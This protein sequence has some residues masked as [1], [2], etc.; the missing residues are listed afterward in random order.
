MTGLNFGRGGGVAEVTIDAS[1]CNACGLCARVCKG[2]PLYMEG[3]SVRV[4]QSRMFG[5]IACGHCMTVCPNDAITVRGRDFGPEDMLALPT[6]AQRADYDALRNLLLARRSVREFKA[7]EL[8][9]ALVERILDA[10]STA[11]MGVPPSEVGVLVFEGRAAVKAFRDDLLQV[12]VG[13]RKMFALPVGWA[14]R[15]FM[16]SADYEAMQEF[17]LPAIEKYVEGAREGEDWFFYDAPLALYFYASAQ[18]DMADPF[19]SATYAMLAGQALGLGSCMLGFPGYAMKQSKALQAKYALPAHA[20][21]GIVVIF[22]YPAIRHRKAV[23]RRFARV[24]V[25]G[26]ATGQ[27]TSNPQELARDQ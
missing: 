25:Y 9:P 5:C 22:G 14:M 6:L 12:L 2:A 11:P 20:Q 3:G 10:A 1:L 18:A 27:N 26:E 15:P 21:Q 19:I 17:V 24:Q 23:R 16:S 4:D 13:W 8:E 7:H